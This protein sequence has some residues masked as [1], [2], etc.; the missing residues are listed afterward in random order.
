P[1]CPHLRRYCRRAAP[2]ARAAPPCAGAAPAG[3]RSC[4]RP[5]LQATALAA[6]VAYAS[7]RQPCPRA[8][9]PAPV[10]NCPCKGVLA[11][12][13]RALIG[14]LGRSRLL[15]QGGF[16]RGRSP[17]YRGA[18]AAAGLA[19]GGRPC[20]GAGRGWLPLLLAVLVANV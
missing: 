7:R 19:V 17:P 11:V 3:G 10:G 8:T 12:A 20:M 1:S 18:L 14:G 4:Q 13:G 6:G 15:L 2:R 9:T 16:G 5:F